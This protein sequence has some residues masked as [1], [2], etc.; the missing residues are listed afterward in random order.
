M[1]DGDDVDSA[2]ELRC[3][4]VCRMVKRSA[5]V[6]EGQ[7]VVRVGGVA[8]HIHHHRQ[9]TVVA[10]Q[11]VGREKRGDWLRQVNACV[12][13]IAIITWCTAAAMLTKTI[14]GFESFVVSRGISQQCSHETM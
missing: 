4:R 9:D 11:H 7:R 3:N 5:P 12:Q 6:A 10:V 13:S 14:Q 1:V 2:A 8:A